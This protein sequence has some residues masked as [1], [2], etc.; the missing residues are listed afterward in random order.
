MKT[1]KFPD[2]IAKKVMLFIYYEIVHEVQNRQK[3]RNRK[4][5]E[6]RRRKK[7]QHIQSGYNN[8]HSIEQTNNIVS[9]KPDRQS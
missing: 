4:C 1:M 3:D 9:C 7:K 2:A 5:K 8:T 6:E